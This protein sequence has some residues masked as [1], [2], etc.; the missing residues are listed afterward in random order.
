MAN[1][2]NWTFGELRWFVHGMELRTNRR[3][4]DPNTHAMGEGITKRFQLTREAKTPTK[5]EKSNSMSTAKLQSCIHECICTHS[6]S[7][8]AR[9]KWSSEVG[10]TWTWPQDPSSQYRTAVYDLFTASLTPI[11]A[12]FACLWGHLLWWLT[13]SGQ[14]GQYAVFGQR[15]PQDD[16]WSTAAAYRDSLPS[17]SLSEVISSSNRDKFVIEIVKY[18]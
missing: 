10:I 12:V 16:H 4:D 3:T 18:A 9:T 7:C 17:K 15:W 11:T 5:N 8:R 1:N 14:N 6:I 13:L 2:L